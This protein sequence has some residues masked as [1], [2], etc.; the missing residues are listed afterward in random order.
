M[1]IEERNNV[2]DGE[3]FIAFISKK[4]AKAAMVALECIMENEEYRDE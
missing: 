1:Y 4:E 2:P 3:Y